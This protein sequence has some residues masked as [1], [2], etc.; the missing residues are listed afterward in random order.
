MKTREDIITS[1]C[2]TM[3]HDYGLLDEQNRNAIY[4]QA[5]QLFDNDVAP[6][7]EF[8]K[9]WKER[10]IDK[11][12]NTV[13]WERDSAEDFIGVYNTVLNY[14]LVSEDYGQFTGGI[15]SKTYDVGLFYYQ[16]IWWDEDKYPNE[17]I[18]TRIE[19]AD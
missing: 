10:L 12:N 9:D 4:R 5:A 18:R 6:H 16:C 17:I 19:D 11:L 2:Y 3:R 7:M 1:M 8:K 14:P 13:R 15:V